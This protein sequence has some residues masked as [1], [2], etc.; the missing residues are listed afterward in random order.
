MEKISWIEKKRNEKLLVIVKGK[1][2]FINVN[3]VSRL[4]IVEHASRYL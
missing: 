3:K 2:T 1:C 4:K